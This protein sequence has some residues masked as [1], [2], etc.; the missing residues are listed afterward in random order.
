MFSGIRLFLKMP[1]SMA[2]MK[3]LS[4]DIVFQTLAWL[5]F[6]TLVAFLNFIRDKI[7]SLEFIVIIILL[8]ELFGHYLVRLKIWRQKKME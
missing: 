4:G 6:I 2:D 7:E 3:R 8:I 1:E 5:P